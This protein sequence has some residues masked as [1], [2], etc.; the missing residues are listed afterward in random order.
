MIALSTGE[1]GGTTVQRVD[2]AS[3]VLVPLVSVGWPLRDG[4]WLDRRG[5]VLATTRDLRPVLVDLADGS[6]S[7]LPA[8]GDEAHVVL[9]SPGSG[10]V[11]LATGTPGALRLVYQGG[12]GQAGQAPERLNAIAGS[13]LPLAFDPVGKRLALQV[14]RGARCHLFIHEIGTDT[15]TELP[16]PPGMSDGTA[17]WAGNRLRFTYRSPTCPT[18]LA[19]VAVPR[20]G[21][22][23]DRRAG[24]P[25]RPGTSA[26]WSLHGGAAGPGCAPAHLETF[27]GPAGEIEAVVYGDWRT[28]AEV[29]VALHGGPDAAWELDFDPLLQAM[30]AAGLAV[31]APNPRGSVGYG[32]K[33][34][35]A[36]R[37]GW[38][39]HDMADVLAVARRLSTHRHGAP[40]AVYGASYGAFLALLAGAAAPGLWS[41]CAAVAPFLSTR[42]L[43]ESASP[44]VRD[45]LDRL[46]A[47]GPAATD[48]DLVE[49]CPKITARLLLV[50]GDRDHVVPVDQSRSLRHHLRRA[51]RRE[52]VDFTYVEV[53]GAGHEPLLSAA[54]R[55]AL[56]R[57][58]RTGDWSPFGTRRR[59]T[60]IDT[61]ERR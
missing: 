8:P 19:T 17:A 35:D 16:V 61:S 30:A 52:G 34:R 45:M 24:A 6:V 20:P 7:G 33:F 3:G 28:A 44:P 59:R 23:A 29:V 10:R 56:A 36:I 60:P 31:V 15:L 49:R 1:D 47:R 54:D 43:Y 27:A 22:P 5:R 57:F 41:R 53:A 48:P 50:H 11:L 2:Q 32:P 18:G 39:G 55:T 38:G 14:R 46:A 12:D 21:A 58:L 26:G 40:L 4:G 13:V 37:G 25:D 9:A 51:G 42:R